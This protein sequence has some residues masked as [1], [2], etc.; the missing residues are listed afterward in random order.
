MYRRSPLPRP[1][2]TV[3]T[4]GNSCSHTRVGRFSRA[5][6]RGAWSI[7]K[8]LPEAGRRSAGGTHAREFEEE[9][10]FSAQSARYLSLGHVVQAGGKVVHA[11][12]FEGDC[13]PLS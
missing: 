9:T 6:T 8:G 7:P 1:G 4:A 10:G 12:A 2:Q 3:Q 5:R 11:W 13:D